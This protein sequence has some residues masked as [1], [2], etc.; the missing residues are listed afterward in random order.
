MGQ[1][2]ALSRRVNI[3]MEKINQETQDRV[4]RK[5]E[6]N[7][8]RIIPVRFELGAGVFQMI[9]MMYVGKFSVGEEYHF[10]INGHHEILNG[11]DHFSGR[12]FLAHE[13]NLTLDDEF[14]FPISYRSEIYPLALINP[15]DEPN[16][17]HQIKQLWDRREK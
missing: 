14:Y 6:E 8:G 12:H 3:K 17:Y 1:Q 10:L 7:V 2:R 16:I 9:Q 5:L 11:S 4:I 15:K 13:I